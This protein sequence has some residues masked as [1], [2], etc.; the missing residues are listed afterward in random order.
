MIQDFTHQGKRSIMLSIWGEW[1]LISIRASVAHVALLKAIIAGHIRHIA[2]ATAPAASRAPSAAS[3]R[4][5]HVRLVLET[6][7]WPDP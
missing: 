2:A 3:T 6:E 1:V 7:F 5:P 4:R